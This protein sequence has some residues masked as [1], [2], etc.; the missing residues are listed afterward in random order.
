MATDT[1]PVSNGSVV[2]S[3]SSE[4]GKAQNVGILDGALSKLGQ[5]RPD[6]LTEVMMAMGSIGP[7]ANPLH[8]KMNEAHISQVLDLAAKH[9]ER[10]YDLACRSQQHERESEKEQ[11]KYGFAAL[12]VGLAVL[13]VAVW[14]LKDQPHILAPVLAGVGGLV[15]GF[16]GG[17]GYA[18]SRPQKDDD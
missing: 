11:R 7:T 14:A 18:K 13:G 3:N 2:E 4:D 17:Q 16:L 15:T 12:I 6:Q 8:R 10:E 9:D 5:K 1:P